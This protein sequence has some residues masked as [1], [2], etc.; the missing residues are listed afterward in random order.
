MY[1]TV[2]FINDCRVCRQRRKATPKSALR[3]RYTSSLAVAEGQRD[4]GVPVEIF[5]AIERLGYTPNE[6]RSR[7]SLTAYVKVLSH[8]RD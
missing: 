7:V 3:S 1:A 4:T 6:N 8:R 2:G 5:S